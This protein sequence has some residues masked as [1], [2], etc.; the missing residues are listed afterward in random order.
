VHLGVVDV[1]ILADGEGKV[2]TPDQRRLLTMRSNSPKPLAKLIGSV[3][4]GAIFIKR[5]E[6]HGRFADERDFAVLGDLP[7]AAAGVGETDVSLVIDGDAGTRMSRDAAGPQRER[8]AN[9]N[10]NHA[11]ASHDNLLRQE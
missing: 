8:G 11:M 1:A 4:E 9:G 10:R 2:G 6:V 5:H 7:D 3:G